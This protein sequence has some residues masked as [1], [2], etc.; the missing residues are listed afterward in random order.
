MSVFHICLSKKKLTS[1][2]LV[3][4]LYWCL[5]LKNIENK[6]FIE[7]ERRSP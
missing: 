3:L 1:T 4:C 2:L 5:S 6:Y 7:F